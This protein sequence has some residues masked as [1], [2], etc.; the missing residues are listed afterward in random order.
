MTFC[1]VVLLPSPK[2]Q[3]HD[4]GVPVDWSVNWTANGTLPE[5][6]VTANAAIGAVDNASFTTMYPVFTS[7]SLLHPDR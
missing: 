4:V 6:G 7:E 5:V 3:I 1:P 2:S